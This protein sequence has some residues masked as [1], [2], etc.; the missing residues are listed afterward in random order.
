MKMAKS[1]GDKVD[2]DAVQ[3]GFV[4]GR[5]IADAVFIDSSTRSSCGR[6]NQLY[7]VFADLE[8]ALTRCLG[9]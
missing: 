3:F 5:G 9:R 7:F 6:K 1:L 4:L 2:T 8:K